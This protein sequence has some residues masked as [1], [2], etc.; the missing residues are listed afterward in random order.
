MDSWYFGLDDVNVWPIPNP[1]FRSVVKTNSNN[2]VFSWNTLAGIAYQLQYATNLTNA[3]WINLSTNTAVGPVLT[4]TNSY[5][6]D[7]QRFYRIRQ[8]P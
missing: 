3:N 1:S 8:L 4:L 5:G 6:T 7:P 2:I